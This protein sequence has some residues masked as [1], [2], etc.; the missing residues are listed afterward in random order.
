MK[1]RYYPAF[2]N[3]EGKYVLMV[4]AGSVAAQKIRT[5]LGLEANIH[6]VAPD[7]S[8]NVKR[9]ASQKKIY[10]QRR[11]F[12]LADLKK[13]ELV[14]CATNDMVLNA[15]VFAACR[16]RK[17]WVNV[18]D[19]PALC[20]FIVPSV[21]RRGRLVAAISTGGA[22][23]ALARFIKQKSEKILTPELAN[24]AEVLNILRPE[25]KKIPIAARKKKLESIL[26]ET[27]IQ[28]I[29]GKKIDW[30]LS[31]VRRKTREKN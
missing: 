4:G 7:A 23:P 10:L 13:A 8:E 29:K 20:D 22:S 19:R 24:L 31:Y 26:T 9:W 16:A 1:N 25:L 6:V 15:Q 21:L 28:K 14:F 3:L 18:V 11:R 2:L 5:L 27:L 12:S 17:I 30:V